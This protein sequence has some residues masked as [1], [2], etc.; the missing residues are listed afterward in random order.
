MPHARNHSNPQVSAT[1]A[2]PC[3]HRKLENKDRSSRDADGKQRLRDP[4]G[5]DF[6]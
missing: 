3:Q 1:I 5:K 6:V 2:L 4:D